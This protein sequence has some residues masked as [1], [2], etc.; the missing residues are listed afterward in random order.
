[1]ISLS[2]SRYRCVKGQ[3][4]IAWA[5]LTRTPLERLFGLALKRGLD[6]SEA[7]W[8]KPCY[9]IHTWG[10]R[11]S[12]DVVFLDSN[13]GVKG[14]LE[15]VKPW[16]ICRSFFGTR[17]VLELCSGTV[18]AQGIKVGDRLEFLP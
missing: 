17:S 13:G 14:V 8:L 5:V 18:A 15:D 7:L 9:V 11:F 16:R 4:F 3:T 2:G 10:M 12:L 1:M 6:S